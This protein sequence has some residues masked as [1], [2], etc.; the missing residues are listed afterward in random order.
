MAG[1]LMADDEKPAKKEKRDKAKDAEICK[2]ALERY[3]RWYEKER[4]NIDEAYTDLKFRA[5][6]QWPAKVLTERSNE[7][8]PVLTINRIPQ[9][10]RQVTGDMRQ[11]RPSIKTVPVDSRGDKDTAETLAGMIRYIENR[12]DAAAIYMGGAES[13]V[14]CGIGHWMV[15]KEYSE[16][17]FNQELRIV[18]I[19]DQVAVACDPDAKLPMREDAKWWIIPVDMSREAFKENYPNVALD[20]FDDADD[21]SSGWFDGDFIRVAAY[22]VKKPKSEAKRS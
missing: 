15:T 4:E 2:Q 5:G 11:M 19:D 6:E 16:G 18:G 14:G 3:R 1:E 9:F 10:I 20:D 7:G 21:A 22:W 17:T 13:Q 12:S 8:R